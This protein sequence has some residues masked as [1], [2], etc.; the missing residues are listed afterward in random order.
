MPGWDGREKE[1]RRVLMDRYAGG[2]SEPL[3]VDRELGMV[4]LP[5]SFADDFIGDSSLVIL[6]ERGC[7]VGFGLMYGG[8][9]VLGREVSGGSGVGVEPGDGLGVRP[10]HEGGGIRGLQEVPD[11]LIPGHLRGEDDCFQDELDVLVCRGV[12]NPEAEPG[13][14]LAEDSLGA[15]CGVE[16]ESNGLQVLPERVDAA[17]E[18]LDVVHFNLGFEVPGELVFSGAEIGHESVDALGRRDLDVEG[19]ASDDDPVV[20][21]AAVLDFHVESEP[22]AVV[23]FQ[24]DVSGQVL[25]VV[26]ETGELEAGVGVVVVKPEL[27]R[28]DYFDEAGTVG[29]LAV[30]WKHVAVAE[31]LRG[32]GN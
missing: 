23:A 26:R 27:R 29:S 25:R 30:G 6:R 4:V 1:D 12:G 28:E 17:E 13:S 19:L 5:G 18:E 24:R 22:S 21:G 10:E 31:L 16:V 8:D 7:D 15:S 3:V 20:P 2:V 9:W 14:D 11:L 32:P